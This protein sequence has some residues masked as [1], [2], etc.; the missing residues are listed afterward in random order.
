MADTYYTVS[1]INNGVT[2]ALAV[3]VGLKYTQSF[4]Q[5][6]EGIQDTPVLRVYPTAGKTDITTGTDR[7]T[8]SGKVTQSQ[9]SFH[10]DL[11]ATQRRHLGEDMAKLIPLIDAIIDVIEAQKS[12]PFFGVTAIKA[13]G[14]SWNG[15][16][17]SY[18]R[19]EVHYAGARFVLNLRMF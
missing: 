1:E 18:G 11:Y 9:L 8:F 19:P 17:F 7:T 10:A 16:V 6:T 14:W 13:F 3:A 12:K 2:A 5:L 4:D 15:I